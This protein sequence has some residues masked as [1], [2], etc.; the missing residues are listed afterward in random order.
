MSKARTNPFKAMEA[1]EKLPE[2]IKERVMTSI[3]LAEVLV[4]FTE[5][6]TVNMV[7]TAANLLNNEVP[8]TR[9]SINKPD[10]SDQNK[11]TQS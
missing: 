7:G 6:F 10:I 11:D 3:G 9:D 1:S 4:G 8:K 5:L 2:Q